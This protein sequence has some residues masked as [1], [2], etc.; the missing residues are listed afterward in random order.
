MWARALNIL[1]VT[2]YTSR[3]AETISAE[4]PVLDVE[5]KNDKRMRPNMIESDELTDNE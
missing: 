5:P 2:V 3:L 4:C 1:A